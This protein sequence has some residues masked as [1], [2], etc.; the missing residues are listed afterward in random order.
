M[1]LIKALKLIKKTC[2]EANCYPGICPM[3]KRNK[4]GGCECLI[5]IDNVDEWKPADIKNRLEAY[6][7]TH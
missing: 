7:K 2:S 5:D 4:A 3:A 1:N 6:K